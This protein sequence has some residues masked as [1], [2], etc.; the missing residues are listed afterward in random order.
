M[1]VGPI[2]FVK[3]VGDGITKVVHVAEAVVR[4]A[5]TLDVLPDAVDVV[6]LRT[7][8]RKPHHTE[9][10]VDLREVL[11]RHYRRVVARVVQDEHAVAAAVLRGEF[12][13]EAQEVP[14]VLPG[15]DAV[16]DVIGPVVERTVDDELPVLPGRRHLDRLALGL[17]HLHEMGVQ[18][19]FGLV[20]EQELYP[21][22]GF[23]GLFFS[24]FRRRFTDANAFGSRFSFRECLGRLKTSPSSL[25]DLADA[26]VAKQDV[27]L[28]GHVRAQP[29]DTP[30]GERIAELGGGTLD[31]LDE[32]RTV[33]PG[34]LGR[35]ARTGPVE[36]SLRAV[37]FERVE[38]VADALRVAAQDL[39]DLGHRVTKETQAHGVGAPPDAVARPPP[40]QIF[41]L[42]LLGGGR[43][44]NEAMGLH[45]DDL[46]AAFHWPL[47]YLSA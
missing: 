4:Q 1:I 34:R 43:T 40:E 46:L 26:A 5:R 3:D 31:D 42:A 44:V 38:P 11:P 32:A 41:D 29:D 10:G 2:E 22:T 12:G 14:G 36:Q 13:N 30:D 33:V 37:G 9:S 35:A 7:V 18:V 47:E 45:G 39:G 21:G 28:A 15:A 16:A 27:H 25:H 24:S 20:E 8:G 17:P 23:Q 6:Q 19:D